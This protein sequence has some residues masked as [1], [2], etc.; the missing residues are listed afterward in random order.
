MTKTK[1][2]NNLGQPNQV[3]IGT[4]I[5]ET[6]DNIIYLGQLIT[7]QNQMEKEVNQ[8]IASAWSK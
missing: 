5:I 7:F 1:I 8:R 6:V 4:E 2:L 3:K